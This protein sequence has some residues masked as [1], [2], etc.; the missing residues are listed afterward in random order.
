MRVHPLFDI[1]EKVWVTDCGRIAPTLRELQRLLPKAEIV[2]YCPNGYAASFQPLAR[3]L[4]QL[5]PSR[6]TYGRSTSF[7]AKKIDE[8]VQAKQ[9]KVQQQEERNT[10]V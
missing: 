2:G 6:S 8:A 4:D 10:A 9:G 3:R 7:R 5:R 1:D